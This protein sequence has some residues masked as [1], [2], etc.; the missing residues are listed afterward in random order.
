MYSLI[1]PHCQSNF[2]TKVKRAK[3]CSKSCSNSGRARDK[4]LLVIK[5]TN[6]AQESNSTHQ[7]AF[8]VELSNPVSGRTDRQ[9]LNVIPAGGSLSHNLH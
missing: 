9:P 8:I 4:Q 6:P 7:S 5:T 3:Y 1:C 2:A